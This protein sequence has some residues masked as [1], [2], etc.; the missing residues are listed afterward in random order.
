[1]EILTNYVA[2]KGAISFK[3]KVLLVISRNLR[4]KSEGDKALLR[5]VLGVCE[6]VIAA[7]DT[8]E[9]KSLLTTIV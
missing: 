7:S 5:N 2:Q 3:I 6:S 8:S 4:F 9:D 1:M